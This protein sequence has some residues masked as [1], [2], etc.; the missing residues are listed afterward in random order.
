MDSS[1]TSKGFTLVELIIVII[2][3]AIVSITAVSR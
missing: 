1:P 2:I 3:L